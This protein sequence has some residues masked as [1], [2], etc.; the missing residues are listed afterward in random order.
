M[1]EGQRVALK[2][3]LAITKTVVIPEGAQGV[4]VESWT[5]ELWDTHGTGLTTVRSDSEDAEYFR[6]TDSTLIESAVKLRV[7]LDLGLL[8]TEYQVEFTEA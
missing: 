1:E 2:A 5:E 3:A 7:Q 6:T 4:V 8:V